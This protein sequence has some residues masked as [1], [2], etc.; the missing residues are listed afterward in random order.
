MASTGSQPKTAAAARRRRSHG[1]SSLHVQ[2][3]VDGRELWY[4][5]WYAG[6]RRLNRRVGPDDAP[7]Q[8]DRK[9][10]TLANNRQILD[11][12]LLPRFGEILVNRIKRGQVEALAAQLAGRQAGADAREHAE[13]ALTGLHLRRPP[14]LVPG[15][16]P[17]GE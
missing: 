8:I 15:E 13:T 3:R 16:P 11:F 4:G 7:R 9:P 14:A 1:T 5:R 10:T 17:A 2:T 12:R 6:L